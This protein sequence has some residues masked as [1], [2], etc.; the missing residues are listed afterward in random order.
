ER[1]RL[2][3]LFLEAVDKLCESYLQDSRF[4]EAIDLSQRILVRDNCWERAYRH[5]MQAYN[6]LGDRGQLARTYQRCLQTLK[7]EL[8][9]PPSQETQDLYRK[10]VHS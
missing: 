8:D 9:V 3:T 2:A 1:E 5:L 6:A 10:L 4:N 7:D